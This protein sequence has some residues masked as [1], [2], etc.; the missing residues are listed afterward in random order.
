MKLL[1][2]DTFEIRTSLTLEEI[3]TALKKEVEPRKWFRW[4]SRDQVVFEGDVSRDGFK[5][6][7]IIN[8]RNSFAPIIRGT[9]KQSPNGTTVLIRMN[10]H[11][12]VI[13]F[14]CIWLSGFIGFFLSLNYPL[15]VPFAIMLLFISVMVLGGFWYEVQET[16]PKLIS[17]LNGQIKSEQIAQADRE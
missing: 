16:K 5:I 4:F 7:R 13:V 9:F 15:F 3:I 8:Y 10:L 14:L 11:P 2:Y 12:L 1:P 6:G 17:I